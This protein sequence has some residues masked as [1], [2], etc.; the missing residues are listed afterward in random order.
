MINI[1]HLEK[2]IPSPDKFGFRP[3]VRINC[4]DFKD[5]PE[6]EVE[7]IFGESYMKARGRRVK[8][9]KVQWMGYGPTDNTWQSKQDA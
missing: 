1:Q 6:D 4:R 9:Y 3:G 5:L 2:Y 8:Y 7:R